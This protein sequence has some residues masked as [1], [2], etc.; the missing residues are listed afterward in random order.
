MVVWTG[1]N[2]HSPDSLGS[3]A[4]CPDMSLDL[5]ESVWSHFDLGNCLARSEWSSVC[6]TEPAMARGQCYVPRQM[7]LLLQGYLGY[8]NTAITL[9]S[10]AFTNFLCC[11]RSNLFSPWTWKG[12]LGQL[13]STYKG[14]AAYLQRLVQQGVL[15]LQ[16]NYKGLPV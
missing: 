6:L 13:V 5:C 9:L 4:L 11:D 16:L 14:S 12:A 15:G 10:P 1:L 7:S 3:S 2:L 8:V